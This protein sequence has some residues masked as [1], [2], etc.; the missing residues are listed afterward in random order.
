[1]L[2]YDDAMALLAGL[3]SRQVRAFVLARIS[4][5]EERAVY[6]Y[7]AAGVS[8]DTLL[9]VSVCELIRANRIPKPPSVAHG[10]RLGRCC[11]GADLVNTIPREPALERLTRRDRG[12]SRPTT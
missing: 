4:S 2:T 1:M 8:Y 7:R 3:T 12:P 5:R 9:L 10:R 6:D 11:G